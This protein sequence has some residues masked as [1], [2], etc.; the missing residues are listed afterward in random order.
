M[1]DVVSFISDAGG[2]VVSKNIL[3]H[4]GRL[5]WCVR[6]ESVNDFD[7]GWRFFSDIDTEEYLSDADNMSICDFNTI[8][9]IEPA[10]LTI[11]NC[12]VGTDLELVDENGKKYFL[13]NSTGKKFKV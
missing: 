12:K 1:S 5:R 3:R 13:D 6:E 2:S 9:N 11:Y 7:N 4:R 10:I 8:A